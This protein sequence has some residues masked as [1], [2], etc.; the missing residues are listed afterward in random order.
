[1][2]IDY[3][4][5][6]KKTWSIIYQRP[7]LWFVGILAGGGGYSL[8]SYSFGPQSYD[9]GNFVTSMLAKAS[10]QNINSE[11]LG[12]F[13]A[14]L[15]E[16][17]WQL[18]LILSIVIFLLAIFL[19]IVSVASQ[20][21][22]IKV[23]NDLGKN[24]RKKFSFI[25]TIDVGFSY[26]W[27]LFVFKLLIGILIG[28]LFLLALL[29]FIFVSSINPILMII[30]IPIII[31]ISILLMVA[32]NLVIVI[33]LRSI[34]L[35][36][37]N[38]VDATKKALEIIKGNLGPILVTWLLVLLVGFAGN[39]A[40]GISIFIVGVLVILLIL[41][42]ALISKI[43]AVITTVVL[44][45]FVLAIVLVAWGFINSLTSAYWTLIYNKLITK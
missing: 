39:L 40:I 6:L 34:V 25:K 32:I 1:M 43:A 19:L 38:F 10:D 26:F 16:D 35:F 23:V 22:L 29:P 4:G 33:S 7:Y 15:F 36:D 42:S 12:Q 3:F 41:L 20:G 37:L 27:Q 9:G 14:Q 31:L 11:E 2:K 21:G 30:L 8:V 17:N 28:I 44:G 45:L 13:L 24:S 5:I 18:M